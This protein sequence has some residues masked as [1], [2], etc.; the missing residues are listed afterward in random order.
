MSLRDDRACRLAGLLGQVNRPGG[1]HAPVLAETISRVNEPFR[2]DSRGNRLLAWSLVER[3]HR[4]LICA[5]TAVYRQV[6]LWLLSERVVPR[7]APFDDVRDPD[8]WTHCFAIDR[9]PNGLPAF[10]DQL[11]GIIILC[12]LPSSIDQGAALDFYT[13]PNDGAPSDTLAR[14]EV[15][16]LVHIVKYSGVDDA[17]KGVALHALAERMSAIVQR[18]PSFDH[19]VIASVPGHDSRTVSWSQ[20]L[21]DEVGR[22]TEHRVIRTRAR[23]LI[24]APAKAGAVDLTHEFTIDA[25]DVANAVVLIVDDVMMSGNT[26]NAV[27]RAARRAGAPEVHV[28]VAARTLR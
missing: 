27:A 19:V 7:N 1:P 2:F 24:R 28:L 3:P 4:L 13:V 17:G 21:A 14:S 5:Q 8:R 26:V 11:T 9:V 18:L 23:S 25:G 15:G 12:N 22:M 20:R 16:D 10:L 6:R